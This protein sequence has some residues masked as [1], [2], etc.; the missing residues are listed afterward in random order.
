MWKIY[1]TC[2]VYLCAKKIYEDSRVFVEH[3]QKNVQ[4]PKRNDTDNHAR[5]W[6]DIKSQTIS[7]LKPM[8]N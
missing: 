6:M 3:D 7:S 2:V 5:V 8:N 4:S 1:W